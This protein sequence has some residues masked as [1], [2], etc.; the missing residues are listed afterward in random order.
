MCSLCSTSSVIVTRK[1][2]AHEQGLIA[3]PLVCQAQLTARVLC[4]NACCCSRVQRQA[5][6]FP[7]D[8]LSWVVFVVVLLLAAF[9]VIANNVH[10]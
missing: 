5:F 4:P 7:G 9:W 1:H 3:G 6:C 10:R 2:A 8:T